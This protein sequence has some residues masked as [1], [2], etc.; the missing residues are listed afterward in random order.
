MKLIVQ[1]ESSLTLYRCIKLESSKTRNEKRSMCTKYL[2]G[3]LSSSFE[4]N[5]Q[6]RRHYWG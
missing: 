2:T 6:V 3:R 5:E 4:N 1:G